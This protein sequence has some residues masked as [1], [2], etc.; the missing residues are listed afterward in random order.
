MPDSTPQR[1]LE[2]VREVR[3]GRS[4]LDVVESC[5]RLIDADGGDLRAW[6]HLDS[7]GARRHARRLDQLPVPV[8]EC[9]PLL[10][11]P[12]GVKDII[13]TADMPTSMGSPIYADRRPAADAEIV[14]SLRAAGAVVVGKTTTTEFACFSPAE[15]KNP[16]DRTRTPGGSSSGSAAAV[17]AGMVALAVGT[18]TAGSIIRPASYCGVFGLKPT[19]GVLP[20]AGVLATSETLD[21]V[22]LFGRSPADLDLALGALTDPR[23]SRVSRSISPA[24]GLDRTPKIGVLRWGWDRIEPDARAAI[25]RLVAGAES[26]GGL[27]DEVEMPVELEAVADAAFTIQWFETAIALAGEEQRH[28]EALSQRLRDDLNGGHAIPAVDYELA[29]RFADEWRWR[30]SDAISEFDAVLSPSTL[31][32]PPSGLEST[33]NPLFCRPWTLFGFPALAIPAAWT[34]DRL[35]AGVQLTTTAHNDRR[36]LEV[37]NWLA[38]TGN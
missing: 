27:I 2:I 36:L 38:T 21:T 9:L 19:A 4:V 13:D 28:S 18:Q 7:D 32:V 35:P 10:G 5:L 14:A 15:T 23:F 8:R 1:A 33:G 6:V 29:R 24:N 22:G 30:C 37:A 20:R 3:A 34:P 25:D 31:G 11:V 17:A 26:A 16:L 12:V